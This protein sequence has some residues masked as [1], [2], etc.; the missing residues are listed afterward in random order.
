[1]QSV[2]K[3]VVF[4]LALISPCALRARAAHQPPPSPLSIAPPAPTPRSHRARVDR[5]PRTV[6]GQLAQAP[7]LLTVTARPSEHTGAPLVLT[8][9]D[10]LP[11]RG[12]LSS[13]ARY[14]ARVRYDLFLF[15]TVALDVNP[16]LRSG[17]PL[18]ESPKHSFWSAPQTDDLLALYRQRDRLL[19]FGD[20]SPGGAQ[21]VTGLGMFVAAAILSAH[22]PRPLRVLF[23]H[24]VHLGPAIFDRS[25]MGIG[26]GGR[27]P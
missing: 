6:L 11:L 5:K 17:R 18:S 10:L 25:G 26:F 12:P 27:F 1:V 15:H 22:A 24:R 19:Y 13:F 8:V 21:L 14:S 2:I 4:S 20:V 7:S 16:L 3:S 23:D 9:E